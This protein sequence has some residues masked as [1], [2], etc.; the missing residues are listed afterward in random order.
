VRVYNEHGI[1]ERTGTGIFPRE[2]MNRIPLLPLEQEGRLN[3]LPLREN[4]RTGVC[5]L[6]LDRAAEGRPTPGGLW[7]PAFA[8]MTASWRGHVTPARGLPP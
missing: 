5:L 1:A 8:G 4:F 3:D 2:L 6:P 7:I